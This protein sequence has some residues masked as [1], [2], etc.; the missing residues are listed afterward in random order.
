[1]ARV[2][3]A[4]IQTHYPHPAKRFTSLCGATLAERNVPRFITGS[5]SDV[6]C[7]SCLLALVFPPI[8]KN[9]AG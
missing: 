7:K 9:P 4:V 5:R 6:T 2:G 1:M 8:K 3:Q